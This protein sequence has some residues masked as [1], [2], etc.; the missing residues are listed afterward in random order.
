[1]IYPQTTAADSAERLDRIRSM[2]AELAPQG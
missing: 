2:L 1:M